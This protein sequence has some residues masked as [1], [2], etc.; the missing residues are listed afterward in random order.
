MYLPGVTCSCCSLE[1]K[2][3]TGL[4]E[5]FHPLLTADFVCHARHLKPLQCFHICYRGHHRDDL[6]FN[7][8][9]KVVARLPSSKPW[10]LI[11]ID[12]FC[13]YQPD[14]YPVSISLPLRQWRRQWW[15]DSSVILKDGCTQKPPTMFSKYLMEAC[16]VAPW[17][18]GRT[19]LR[20]THNHLF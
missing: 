17:F 5:K 14:G 9:N 12:S 8:G 4:Q 15:K 2:R 6:F 3:F 18:A 20:E 10:C 16:K 7:G 13:P 1:G 11:F 19:R